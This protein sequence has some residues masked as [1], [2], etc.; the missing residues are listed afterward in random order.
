MVPSEY[1]SGH[2][3]VRL[4]R[5]DRQPTS[6]GCWS[7]PPRQHRARYVAG[8]TMRDRWELASP[9]GGDRG[10]AATGACTPVGHLRARRKRHAVAKVA[11]ARDLAGWRWSLAVLEE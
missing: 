1:S 11:I 10:D 5:Q 3:R 4:D 6:V 9:G 2:S 8:K 7:R